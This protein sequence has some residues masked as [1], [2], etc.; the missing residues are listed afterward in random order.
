[1]ATLGV[2]TTIVSDRECTEPK[3][4]QCCSCYYD[5][6]WDCTEEGAVCKAKLPGAGEVLV[7]DL[8]CEMRGTPKPETPAVTESVKAVCTPTAVK[9]GDRPSETCLAQYDL[10][11][12]AKSSDAAEVV[13]PELATMDLEIMNSAR[14]YGVA[15]ALALAV[16]A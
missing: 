10:K 1:M 2:T 7:G 4:E 16:V 14:N 13:M 11:K 5:A 15:L 8:V 6:K 9:R 12:A 3:P